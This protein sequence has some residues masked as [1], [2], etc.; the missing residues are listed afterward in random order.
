[1]PNYKL[2][3]VSLLQV[4]WHFLWMPCFDGTST[5]KCWYQ[6]FEQLPGNF[7]RIFFSISRNF[8]K[9]YMHAK[10]QIKWTIQTEITD[11]GGGRICP[12]PTIPICKKPGLFRVNCFLQD[13]ASASIQSLQ[14]SIKIKLCQNLWNGLYRHLFWYS[15]PPSARY[16]W[17][18]NNISVNQC[19]VFRNPSVFY[20]YDD[21][22]I[23]C[24][25]SCFCLV[26]SLWL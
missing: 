12:L 21:S 10:F 23:L 14:T 26:L 20:L 19:K 7:F 5:Q 9:Y 11:G 25:S 4:L 16:T 22:L 13:D 2:Q 1:M 18:Y 17:L 15:L 8:A 24:Y 6:H 3:S